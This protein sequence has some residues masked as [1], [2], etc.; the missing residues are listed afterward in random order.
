MRSKIL[1]LIADG[2]DA[3]EENT[4]RGKEQVQTKCWE[5]NPHKFLV[6]R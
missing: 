2:E 3:F 6:N 1:N 5:F 4:V